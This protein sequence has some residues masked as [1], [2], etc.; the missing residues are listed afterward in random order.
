MKRRPDLASERL[1]S[2][3]FLLQ[4]KK[5]VTERKRDV[6]LCRKLTESCSHVFGIDAR[7]PGEERPMEDIG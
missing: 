6:S 7:E 5:D 1:K 3:L 4:N 2:E